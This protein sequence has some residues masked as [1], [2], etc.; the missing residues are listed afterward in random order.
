MCIDLFE[1]F[2]H[3]KKYTILLIPKI[4]IVNYTRKRKFVKQKVLI[5][6]YFISAPRAI[7]RKDDA[8]PNRLCDTAYNSSTVSTISFRVVGGAVL[9]HVPMPAADASLLQPGLPLPRAGPILLPHAFLPQREGRALV[10]CFCYSVPVSQIWV[11]LLSC[12]V[13]DVSGLNFS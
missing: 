8:Q 4:T 10:F 12:H 6:I 7:L 13:D 9:I 2:D 5:Q 1:R 11:V 3:L